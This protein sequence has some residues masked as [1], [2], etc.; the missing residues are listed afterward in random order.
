M[1]RLTHPNVLQAIDFGFFDGMPYLIMDLVKGH[2]LSE[3][4]KSEGQLSLSAFFE[5][6]RQVCLGL[7]HAHLN[8]IVHRD[9]K[10]ANIMLLQQD[11][12]DGVQVKIVDFGLAKMAEPESSSGGKLT[13]TGDCMG[14]PLYMS[15]EQCTGSPID[16]R[17]DIYSL[18][19]VF[20]EALTG[21]C[22]LEADS[23]L[24]VMRAHISESPKEFPADSRIPIT[25]Q[26]LIMR[27]LCK[28]PADRPQSADHVLT[29]LKEAQARWLEG[30][31]AHASE[32]SLPS[33]VQ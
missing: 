7:S 18:G 30:L 6:S 25:L 31:D 5:I 12:Q 10:P 13:Q 8:G 24:E 9:L 11:G 3:K 26:Q 23:I 17:S 2:S 19:C 27:M 16:Q 29:D 1:S 22:P 21:R 33:A 4:L 15:P 28:E 32:S 20:Y 14:S